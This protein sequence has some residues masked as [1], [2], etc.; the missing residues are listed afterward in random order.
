MLAVAIIVFREVLE[1]ALIISIVMA[2][3][4][5]IAKRNLSISGG[6]A[7]GV[8]GAGLVAMF[9]A[10]ISEAFSG[11][12]QEILHAGIL[13]FAVVMLAWHNLWM[14]HH[15]REMAQQAKDVG[16]QVAAGIRPLYALALICGF[17]VLREGAETVLFV[18]SVIASAQEGVASLLLGG[19][20]GLAAGAAL[21]VIL[22]LGLLR[23]PVSRL[24]TVTGWMIL[25]LA[26][27]LAAQG[28][29]FLVQASLLPPLGEQLW[30]TSSLLSESSIL[31]RVLHTLT[32]YIAQPSGIELLAYI[33]TLMA[34][35]IPM[36][37]LSRARN[38]AVAAAMITVMVLCGSRPAWADLRVR[39]PTVEY[40]ELELE[41]NGLFTFDN[42]GS[43]LN[44]Q[45]SY[46]NSIGY[47]VLPWWKIELEGE[48]AGGPGVERTYEATT[49]ENTFQLT[50]P[51]KYFFNLGL[52]VEYSQATG[53]TNPNSFTFGPIIQKE[54]NDILGVDSLHTLD[55]FFSRGVGRGSSKATGFQYAWQSRL[56][57]NR[58]ID[59]AIEFYG[60]IGDVLHTAPF[61]SQQHFV[62]PAIVG[63]ASFAPYGKLKYEVGYLFGY[64]SATPRGAVRWLLEYEIA[65]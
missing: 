47:G 64:T 43:D 31:G 48:L 15:G 28:T 24:F 8:L 53:Q 18:F 55:V 59:P 32:G 39:M 16:R 7:G 22:Y 30:D 26:A 46:T 51:G 65:F 61:S 44:G 13:L 21:G 12:G 4:V 63:A 6:V 1:A 2:A 3:S 35:G 45:Q 38:A 19:L 60:T 52:F 57:L 33:L 37:A 41:H 42:K 34:I 36:R 49:F 54:L 58:Y 56:L 29:A 23:I 25:L 27:G 50:E 62:G 11:A 17:A 9:A 20:I 5:G 10:S 14:A 40:R